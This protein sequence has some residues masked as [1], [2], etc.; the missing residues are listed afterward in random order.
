[1]ISGPAIGMREQYLFCKKITG[2]IYTKKRQFNPGM[3]Y[4][5]RIPCRPGKE[6]NKE[7]D[8]PV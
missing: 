3:F 2:T 6:L 7:Q 8:R 4:F 5:F 1:V